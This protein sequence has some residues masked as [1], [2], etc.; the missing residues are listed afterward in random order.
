MSSICFSNSSRRLRSSIRVAFS[1]SVS[2]LIFLTKL[3]IEGE[4][5][6]SD[7]LAQT[8]SGIVSILSFSLPFGEEAAAEMV[9]ALNAR[10]S[11]A[12][13]AMMFFLFFIIS[14]PLN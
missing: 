11:V 9:T 1:F 10:I 4:L 2:E 3:S 7:E 6:L 5:Q 12:A 13:I 8:I 14:A